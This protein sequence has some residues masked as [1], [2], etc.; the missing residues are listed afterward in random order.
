MEKRSG[1]QSKKAGVKLDSIG[2]WSQAKH[3]II[4]Q[5][6][7]AY[8]QILSNQGYLKF[9]YIDGFCGAGENTSKNTGELLKGSPLHVLGTDSPFTS[10]YFIDSDEGKTGY[11][12]NLCDKEYS[13]L[14]DRIFIETGDSN[15]IIKELLPKFSYKRYDRILCLLDPYGL[16]LDWDVIVKLGNLGKDEG[17]GI[18]DIM[19]NF[20]IMDINRNYGLKDPSAVSK[21][22]PRMKFFWGDDSWYAE[23]YK[24]TG[25][26]NLEKKMRYENLVNAY[27]E[28]LKKQAGFDFAPKPVKL[29]NTI[30]APLFYFCFAS[31]NRTATKVATYLYNKAEESLSYQRRRR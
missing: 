8:T 1:R 16:H 28:R 4:S 21:D 22:D 14:K 31:H 26:F 23:L 30:N 5:Y 15:E 18:V 17:T 20:P 13:H 12:R 24:E 6:A 2:T 7:A 11:L 29:T 27:S 10:Y 25:L 19:I 3:A 9:H